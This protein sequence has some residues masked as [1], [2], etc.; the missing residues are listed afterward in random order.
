M[1]NIAGELLEAWYTLL[2]DNLS[3]PVYRGDAFTTAGDFVLLR[4]ESEA[5][6]KNRTSFATNAV[7]VVEVVTKHDT[8]VN[9]TLGFTVDR[10]IK[11]LVYDNPREHNIVTSSF[12]VT[13]VTFG[14]STSIYEDDGNVRLHRLITRYN[15][16]IKQ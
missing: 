16:R 8:Y 2:N 10:E 15:H 14:G 3:V 12:Q 13:N 1:T 9:E 7:I 5:D 6:A 4:F 11:G